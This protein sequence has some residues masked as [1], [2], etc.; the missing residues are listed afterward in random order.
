M[1]QPPIFETRAELAAWAE[2]YAADHNE[3]AC[4]QLNAIEWIK[5]AVTL[6][7]RVFL[8]QLHG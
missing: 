5:Q 7:R 3:T 2:Q 1:E 4:Q 6:N 8:E